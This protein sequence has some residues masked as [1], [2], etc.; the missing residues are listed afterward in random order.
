MGVPADVLK[1]NDPEEIV[2]V[3]VES[4]DRVGVM[5]EPGQTMEKFIKD[6]NQDV[7]Q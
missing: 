4:F 3:L 5:V 6:G 7:Y 1:R 2:Q